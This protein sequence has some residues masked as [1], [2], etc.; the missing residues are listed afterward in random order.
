M[1][2]KKIITALTI[3]AVFVASVMPVCAASPSTGNTGN[4]NPTSTTEVDNSNRGQMSSDGNLYNVTN[5]ADGGVVSAAQSLLLNNLAATGNA[6]GNATIAAAASNSGVKVTAL[7][8][9]AGDIEPDKATRDADGFYTVTLNVPGVNAG[10]TIAVLHKGANGWETIVPTAVGNGTVTFRVKSF[11]PFA[12]VKLVVSG[13]V[14]AP[15][16]GSDM[17]AVYAL[18]LMGIAGAA[19]CGKKY[20]AK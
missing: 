1:I 7:V 17:F 8:L 20:L 14:N 10:D 11:S 4:Q 5:N 16:T 19:Y 3:A 6:F 2:K 18:A 15:Q 13:S 9:A 12:I